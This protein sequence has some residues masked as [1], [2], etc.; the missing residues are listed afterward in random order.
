MGNSNTINTSTFEEWK[1]ELR[2]L[3]KRNTDFEPD[4]DYLDSFKSWYDEGDSAEETFRTDVQSW[5]L[6]SDDEFDGFVMTGDSSVW[7]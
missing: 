4:E 2:G 7:Q 6:D 3:Y 1:E 5:E